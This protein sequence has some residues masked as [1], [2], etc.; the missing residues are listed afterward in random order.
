MS[1]KHLTSSSKS[2]TH[3]CLFQF[4]KASSV[5]DF[6]VVSIFSI[7]YHQQ[8]S[9]LATLS[10]KFWSVSCIYTF[11]YDKEHVCCNIRISILEHA[12]FWYC[13]W[14]LKSW[15]VE[16]IFIMLWRAIRMMFNAFMMQCCNSSPFHFLGWLLPSSIWIWL[17]HVFEIP[18]ISIETHSISIV[19]L[20]C[21][22]KY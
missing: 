3:D 21:R 5:L 4:L 16:T 14:K 2:E 19:N 7:H 10:V 20:G 8:I 11:L 13:Y 12:S 1:K 15:S 6:R 18:S 9:L 17:S 22:S